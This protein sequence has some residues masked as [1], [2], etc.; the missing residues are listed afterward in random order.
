MEKDYIGK[1]WLNK[2]HLLAIEAIFSDPIYGGNTHQIMW[3][4]VNHNP[5]IPRP[6]KRYIYGV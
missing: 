6:T 1:R 4:R 3:K 5:G 2:L